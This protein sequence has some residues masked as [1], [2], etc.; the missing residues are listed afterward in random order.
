MITLQFLGGAGT[1]TGSKYLLTYNGRRTL[2]DCGL[3][4]GPKD[5]R[6]LNWAPFPVDPKSIQDVLLTH[7]HI[8]HSGYL[9]CLVRDGFSGTVHATTATTELAHIL[10]P[11][12]AHIQ[13]EDARFARKKGYSRHDPALPLYTVADAQAALKPFQSHSYNTSIPLGPAFSFVMRDAGHILGSATV[14]LRIQSEAQPTTMVFSGDLGRYNAPIL[15]DPAPVYEAD[16]LL[17]ESTYGD[18]LHGDESPSEILAQV[19]NET[20]SSGGSV[21]IPS[22]AVGRSQTLLYLLRELR[23]QNKIPS[24]PVY[25]DSP[26]AVDATQIF[27]R[28]PEDYDRQMMDLENQGKS[29]FSFPDLHLVQS[30]EES[31]ALNSISFPCIIISSSGMATSGRILHHLKWRLTNPR[32]TVLLVGYQAVG[33]RGHRLLTGAPEIKIHGEMVPVRAKVRNISA[34]SAHA[35]YQEIVTW[36]RNFKRPPHMTFVV[37]GE[38]TASTALAAHIREELG[39]PTHLPNLTELVTLR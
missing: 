18:R 5:L 19:I 26:M 14:E 27:R 17:I 2:I 31:K 1:T 22:F 20:A 6:R 4:Q 13:E 23:E 39:W 28:H 29:P 11:D 7:A 37:H 33:T 16:Y 30:V 36:L 32:N 24:L 12:S 3:F 38:P 10:L 34:L 21:V 15:N 35:D 25:L 9:P 8:D